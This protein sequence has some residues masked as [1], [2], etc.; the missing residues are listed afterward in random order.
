MQPFRKGELAMEAVNLMWHPGH[1]TCECCN[2]V[3]GD[4]ETFFVRYVTCLRASL[5]SA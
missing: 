2:R 5:S 1:F 3:F 4:S